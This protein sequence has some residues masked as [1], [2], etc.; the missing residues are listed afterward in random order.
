MRTTK[1]PDVEM[2]QTLIDHLVNEL[3]HTL[4][5]GEYFMTRAFDVIEDDGAVAYRLP[6]EELPSEKRRVMIVKPRETYDIVG[7]YEQP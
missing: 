3:R 1:H 4:G 6:I 5:K 2:T 7:T